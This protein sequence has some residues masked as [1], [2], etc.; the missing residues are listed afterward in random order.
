[1]SQSV[2]VFKPFRGKYL[3]MMRPRHGRS[4]ISLPEVPSYIFSFLDCDNIVREHD[5]FQAL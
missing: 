5:T 2:E 3:R 4:G 1:M